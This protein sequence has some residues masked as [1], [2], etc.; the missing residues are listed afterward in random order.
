MHQ[1]A[2]AGLSRRHV[3]KSVSSAFMAG[4]ACP[5]VIVPGRATAQERTLRI[6]QW[7]HFVPGHDQWFNEIF[8]KEWSERNDV[9]V[10]VDNVGLGDIGRLAASEAEAQSG[11]DLVLFL[12]PP[13]TYQDQVIDHREIYNECKKRYGDVFDFAVRSTFN[14][15]TEKHFGFCNAYVPPVITY[16]KDYWD[17]IGAIPESWDQILTAGRR[18]R[19]LHEAPIGISLAPEHNS[20]HSVRA[21]LYSFGG[22]EQDEAGNLT[23]NSSHTLEAIKYVKALYQEA[24]TEEVLTW[25]A[26]SNNRFMLTGE[27]NLTLDTLS[28]ARASEN[29]NLPVAEVL[30][31]GRAPE[32]P[33]ARLAPAFGLITYVIWKFAPNIELAKQFLVDHVGYAQAAFMASGFQNMP[34]FPDSLSD[35]KTLVSNNQGAREGGRYSVLAKAADWTTNMG[36]P[37]YTN[38]AIAEAYDKRI[39]SQ[40]FARA[41]TGELTPENALNHANT[42]MQSIFSSWRAK[43]KI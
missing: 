9:Q 5:A 1:T 26:A 6:L 37:G 22:S 39:L 34:S 38:A 20:E 27:G 33:V 15:R 43:G 8:V 7:K 28:I 10:I 19:L 2:K 24:M 42:Q 12:G 14:P 40:M 21:I 32:G 16:R 18:I 23:L 35:L 36:H 29:K 4:L 30:E 25:D 31:L 41:A 17:S 3:L 13:A 11:H